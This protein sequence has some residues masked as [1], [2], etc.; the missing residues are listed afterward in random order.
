MTRR[1][2]SAVREPDVDLPAAAKRFHELREQANR[3]VGL[4]LN[5]HLLP[6][7][8]QLLRDYV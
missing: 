2:L 1:V 7:Q 6:A 3:Q 8:V 4:P 5:A